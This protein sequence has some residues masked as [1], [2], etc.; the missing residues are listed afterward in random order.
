MKEACKTAYICLYVA[1]LKIPLSTVC[2]ATAA[3]GDATQLYTALLWLQE[4]H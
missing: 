4:W 2:K 3:S 1:Y